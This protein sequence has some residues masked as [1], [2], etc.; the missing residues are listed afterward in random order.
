MYIDRKFNAR[1]IGGILFV[2][3]LTFLSSLILYS[4]KIETDGQNVKRFNSTKLQNRKLT[5]ILASPDY[6]LITIFQYIYYMV[7]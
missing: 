1:S 2:R 3:L 6:N 4:H 7:I 5:Q